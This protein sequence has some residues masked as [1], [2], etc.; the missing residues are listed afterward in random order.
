MVTPGFMNGSWGI[1]VLGLP[2][3]CTGTTG[4]FSQDNYLQHTCPVNSLGSLTVCE[5]LDV[6]CYSEK[7]PGKTKIILRVKAYCAF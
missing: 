5:T 2:A 4:R 6:F 3:S 7:F 1:A